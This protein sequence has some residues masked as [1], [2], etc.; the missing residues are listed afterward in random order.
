MLLQMV[1]FFGILVF[2]RLPVFFGKPVLFLIYGVIVQRFFVIIFHAAKPPFCLLGCPP[3]L[4]LWLQE[5]NRERARPGVGA[6]RRAD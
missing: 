5:K 1:R 4:K 6:D 3:A 2:S